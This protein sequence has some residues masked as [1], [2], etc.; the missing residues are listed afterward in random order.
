M[1]GFDCWIVDCLAASRDNYEM[2]LVVDE[3]Q[4][5]KLIVRGETLEVEFTR[6]VDLNALTD[7][8]L[9]AA[10]AVW[11]TATGDCC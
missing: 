1:R 10:L 11:R 4:L 3:T 9:A 8:E 5:R 6:A 7:R 2:A